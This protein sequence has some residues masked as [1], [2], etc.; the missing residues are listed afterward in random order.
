MIIRI[1]YFVLKNIFELELIETKKMYF[2]H[3][4]WSQCVFQVQ[5]DRVGYSTVQ[6]GTT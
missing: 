2:K 6:V 1:G 5:K 4:E 3:A